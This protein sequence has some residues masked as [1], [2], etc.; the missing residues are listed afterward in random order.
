[1]QKNFGFHLLNFALGVAIILFGFFYL[2]NPNT[3]LLIL[4]FYGSITSLV[5]RFWLAALTRISHSHIHDGIKICWALLVIC[6]PVIGSIS[7]LIIINE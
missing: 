1:M 7:A 2:M 5:I 4:L 3:F 6:L